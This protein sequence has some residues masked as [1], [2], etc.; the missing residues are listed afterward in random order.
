MQCLW[1]VRHMAWFEV[2]TVCLAPMEHRMICFIRPPFWRVT[3]HCKKHIHRQKH[4]VISYALCSCLSLIYPHILC[5]YSVLPNVPKTRL[6]SDSDRSFTKATTNPWNTLPTTSNR[7]FTQELRTLPDR[8]T[9][10][11]AVGIFVA[12]CKWI[13]VISLICVLIYFCTWIIAIYIGSAMGCL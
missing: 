3:Y 5:W 2:D 1:V 4:Y 8:S 9:H 13:Y 7:A 12:Q 10:A 11:H 6:M